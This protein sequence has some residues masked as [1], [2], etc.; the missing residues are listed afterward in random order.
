MA[1]ESLYFQNYLFKKVVTFQAGFDVYYFTGFNG[2]AYMPA[3]GEFHLQD[4]QVIG[5]YPFIDIF[6]SFKLKRAYFFIKMEHV[7]KGMTG[8]N[9]Y[10]V[11]DYPMA[12]RAFKWG[13][14]WNLFD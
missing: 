12:P 2:L 5:N 1:Y 3:T 7:N 6:F 13:L 4:K 10:L 11:P 14:K 8:D 9:F